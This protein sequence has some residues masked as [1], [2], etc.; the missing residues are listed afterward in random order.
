MPTKKRVGGEFPIAQQTP[1]K[2][3]AFAIDFARILICARFH[4]GYC[5]HEDSIGRH[6]ASS[7]LAHAPPSHTRHAAIGV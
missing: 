5:A 6:G 2:E 3:I 7:E 4:S 1:L